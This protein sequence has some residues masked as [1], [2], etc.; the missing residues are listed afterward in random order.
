MVSNSV[1][2]EHIG[3]TVSLKPCLNLCSFQRLNCNLRNSNFTTTVSWTLYKE[4]LSLSVL[5]DCFNLY[6]DFSFL[7]SGLSFFHSSIQKGKKAFLKVFDRDGRCF[8]FP[9]DTDFKR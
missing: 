1:P 3:L 8:N 9:T 4:F 6:I 7:T 2:Y 5:I